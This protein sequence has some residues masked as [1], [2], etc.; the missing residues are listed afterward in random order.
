MMNSIL[1][2]QLLVRKKGRKGFTLIEVIVVLVIL[3]I[4]AAIAI[5]S[6]TGYIDKAREK[7]VVAEARNIQIALQEIAADAY[8]SGNAIPQTTGDWGAADPGFG[9]ASTANLKD[10]V[11]ALTG[12]AYAATDSVKDIIFNNT[13]LAQFVYSDGAYD[14]T[15]ANGSYTVAQTVATPSL[16]P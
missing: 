12:K 3:A 7:A 1:K 5:P 4:L 16:T 10:E 8:G 6:L 15:Y 9:I 13:T 11:Q 2:K 14:A